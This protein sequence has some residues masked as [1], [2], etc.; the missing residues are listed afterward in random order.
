MDVPPGAPVEFQVLRDNDWNQRALEA[1]SV[2]AGP[3]LEL[4]ASELVDGGMVAWSCVHG[5]A[6]RVEVVAQVPGHL[7]WGSTNFYLFV[8]LLPKGG[9]FLS[10]WKK[11]H[12][13]EAIRKAGDW[14]TS[15]HRG[16]LGSKSKTLQTKP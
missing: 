13:S 14:D 6:P 2:G 1:S 16:T 8:G 10:A 7:E 12:A 9:H 4:G 3:G 11:D 5:G 15:I